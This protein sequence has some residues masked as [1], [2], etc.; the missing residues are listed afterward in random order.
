MSV[1]QSC[2]EDR[3]PF[4]SEHKGKTLP[5]SLCKVSCVAAVICNVCYYKYYRA[6]TLVIS[7]YKSCSRLSYCLVS[8]VEYTGFATKTE[9]CF[10]PCLSC[11]AD[12]NQFSQG[13][14]EEVPSDLCK[15][16]H[17]EELHV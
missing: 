11:L 4:V 14:T 7:Y 8:C 16:L 17:N 10:S 15:L 5:E 12:V 3:P 1:S 2:A 6:K 9:S 13:T